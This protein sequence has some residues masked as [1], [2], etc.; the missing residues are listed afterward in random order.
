M[1]MAVR[2]VSVLSDDLQHA[3][4]GS[5]H[6]RPHRARLPAHLGHPARPEAGGEEHED[7]AGVGVGALAG[8]DSA[9]AF[10]N[11]EEQRYDCCHGERWPDQPLRLD[12]DSCASTQDRQKDRDRQSVLASDAGYRVHDGGDPSGLAIGDG[13]DLADC[14]SG[15]VVREQEEVAEARPQR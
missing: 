10:A 12:A 9:E 6:P 3:G 11:P 7:R 15:P 8:E 2:L 13:H 14:V 1:T 5:L 4:Q